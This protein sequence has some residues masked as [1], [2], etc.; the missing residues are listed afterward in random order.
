M[1]RRIAK[2]IH[3]K[4]AAAAK[5]TTRNTPTTAPVLSKKEEP[6][7]PLS[8]EPNVGLTAN[9]VVVEGSPFGRVVTETIVITDGVTVIVCPSVLTVVWTTSVGSVAVGSLVSVIVAVASWEVS[10][11]GVVVVS[12]EVVGLVVD[13]VVEDVLNEVVDDVVVDEELELDELELELLL[14]L[15]LLLLEEEVVLEVVVVVVVL[16]VVSCDVVVVVVVLV[17]VTVGLVM[18]DGIGVV[19]DSLMVDCTEVSEVVTLGEREDPVVDTGE[20]VVDVVSVSELSDSIGVEDKEVGWDDGED[21]KEW[22]REDKRDRKKSRRRRR[23]SQK[24]D[25][26][27]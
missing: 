10:G 23:T 12:S 1:R 24:R 2:T 5:P 9:W 6:D 8:L 26:M 17:G 21:I 4:I 15:L 18:S 16:L 27:E 20:G 25:K 3:R 7:E 13:V 14:L 19:V 22:W 11:G